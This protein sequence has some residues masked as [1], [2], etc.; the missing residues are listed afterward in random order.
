[1]KRTILGLTRLNEGARDDDFPVDFN[2]VTSI[3][4]TACGQTEILFESG[5]SILVWESVER[6]AK[7]QNQWFLDNYLVREE[8]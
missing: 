7:M 2:F 3:K 1:M 6:I 8:G 5:N 4:K